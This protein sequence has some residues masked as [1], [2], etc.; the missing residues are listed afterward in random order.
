MSAFQDIGP[1][2]ERRRAEKQQKRH[3]R[4]MIAGASVS[5]M[6]VLAVVGVATSIYHSNKSDTLTS[7]AQSHP[8][9]KE[10]HTSS[11]Y[12]KA[13]CSTTDFKNA[14]ETSLSKAVSGNKTTNPKAI[15]RA[16]IS[17]IASASEF[18]FNHSESFKNSNKPRVKSAINLCRSL[19]DEAYDELKLALS[20]IDM[21]KLEDLPAQKGYIKNWLSAALHYQGMCID[22][23][24]DGEEKTKMKE[25]MKLGTQ[26]TSNALAIVGATA[27]FLSLLDIDSIAGR[28]LVELGK[29]EKT[30]TSFRSDGLPTWISKETRRHLKEHV[31][32]KLKPNV[33]VAKDGSGDFKTINDALNAMPTKYTGRYV[34]YVKTG[35]YEEHVVMG[36]EKKS[37]TIYGDGSQKSIVTGSLN[38]VDGVQT[39]QTATFAATGFGLMLIGMGFRN[40]AGPQKHQAVALR[41]QSDNAVILNCRMEGYQDTLYA[42]AHYQFYRSCV[43]T[44]TVDFIFGDATAVFQ[45]C[46][47]IVRRP[48]NNQQNIVTA[49]GRAVRFEDTVYVFQNC[50]I[51]AEPALAA[52]KAI[53][54]S[55]LARP[56]KEYSRTIFM[57]SELG[58]FINPDGYMP[59][60]GDF[61][62]NTLFYAEYNNRGAGA[63]TSRRVRWPGVKVLNKQDALAWTIPNVY[64]IPDF[65]PDIS[66]NLAQV[67]K[68]L[69]P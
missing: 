35:I 28:N 44:G 46:L 10:I 57:E 22:A 3:K 61:A 33:T 11:K 21:H 60:E 16:A 4:L 53:I 40:T 15:I 49:H 41:I 37:V 6:L 31:K 24:S 52:D 64:S 38:W 30:D 50:R 7:P 23:F 66:G 56:W 43:I 59:W 18:G 14:C 48:L 17:V 32:A 58:D 34:I 13:I 36:K 69:S 45:N 20:H 63:D 65:I 29:R 47:V 5:V 12:I 25:A 26:L 39:S 67:R 8:S 68:G 9:S 62:L 1:L 19:F 51:T 42:Q 2:A 55:Y 54:R 27:K